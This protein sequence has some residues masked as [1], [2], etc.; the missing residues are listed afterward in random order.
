[1]STTPN[2]VLIVDKR[3]VTADERKALEF[4]QLKHPRNKQDQSFAID[5]ESQTIFEVIQSNRPHSSWFINDEYVLPDGSLYF[6]T[7]VH[8][9]FL[10][11]PSLWSQARNKSVPLQTIIKSS[12][13]DLSLNNE[14]VREKLEPICDIDDDKK[15]SVQ[16]NDEKLFAWFR[17]RIDRLKKHLN[18]EEH[19]FDLLCEYLPDEISEKCQK[20]L[21][22]HGNVKYE[23]PV[24]QKSM[25]ITTST[26]TKT[27][28]TNTTAIQVANKSKRNKK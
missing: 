28:T 1:M 25:T 13:N 7:P 6:V 19:A 22:L 12:L 24:G 3:L 9:I 11:L 16:L 23:L 14:L 17:T 26:S 15:C 21:K 27:T 20:V 2:R 8:L 18:D 10:L 5:R 4:I